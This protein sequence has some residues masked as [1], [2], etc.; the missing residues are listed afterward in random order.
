MIKGA[1]AGQ[2]EIVRIFL[3]HGAD[4]NSVDIDRETASMVAAYGDHLDTVKLLHSRGADLDIRNNEGSNAL[5]IAKDMGANSVASYLAS[6]I[7]ASPAPE[8]ANS[9]TDTDREVTKTG[10]PQ[11]DS[12]SEESGPEEIP[13]IDMDSEE[14]EEFGIGGNAEEVTGTLSHGATQVGP[15]PSHAPSESF[16]YEEATKGLSELSPEYFGK[17]RAMSVDE[18]EQLVLGTHQESEEREKQTSKTLSVQ[19]AIQPDLP[20]KL[21]ERK[22]LV[23]HAGTIRRWKQ[24]GDACHKCEKQAGIDTAPLGTYQL[25]ELSKAP[26]DETM[27]AIA[28]EAIA[29]NLSV[30]EIRKKVSLVVKRAK[31]EASGALTD[32]SPQCVEIIEGLDQPEKLMAQQRMVI[33]LQDSDRL[34][35]EFTF[36]ELSRI[37]EKANTAE[38]KIEKQKRALEEKGAGYVP[39]INFLRLIRKTISAVFEGEKG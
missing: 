14:T 17:P 34:K 4:V 16:S 39:L 23:A 26:N 9:A 10:S 19:F 2:T 29:K 8:D 24:A 7:T 5:D 31:M 30:R 25:Q 13:P 33:L 37:H 6:H 28:R 36:T 20:S 3:D 27:F 18:V 1:E 12:Y 38:T 22:N 21:K 11:G 15:Q 32:M 35:T